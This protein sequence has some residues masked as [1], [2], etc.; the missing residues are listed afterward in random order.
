MAGC[1][2][3]SEHDSQGHSM[4]LYGRATR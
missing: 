3:Q 4:G 2:D 1:A